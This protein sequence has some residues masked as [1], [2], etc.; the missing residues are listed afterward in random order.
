MSNFVIEARRAV[1]IHFLELHAIP[2]TSRREIAFATLVAQYRDW[3]REARAS[4]IADGGIDVPRP[5]CIRLTEAGLAES[6]RMAERN[7]VTH[8][9]VA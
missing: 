7:P 4:L 3:Y 6:A 9:A 1:L 8:L 2:G 5:W